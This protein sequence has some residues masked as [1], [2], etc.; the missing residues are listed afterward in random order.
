MIS[1]I[2][3]SYTSASEGMANGIAFAPITFPKQSVIFE[4]VSCSGRT[5]SPQIFVDGAH[6]GDSDRLARLE[7]EGQLD[8]ILKLD[9]D[10][11]EG[12]S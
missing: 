6:I 7:G 8:E 1:V 9:P 10:T 4:M 5:T 12:E 11:G 2:N 3:T